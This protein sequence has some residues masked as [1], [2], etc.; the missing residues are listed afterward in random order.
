MLP[1]PFADTTHRFLPRDILS[2][3]DLLH[4]L[5]EEARNAYRNGGEWEW[6]P[7]CAE[8]RP[9]PYF[10]DDCD[11]WHKFWIERGIEI[12]GRGVYRVYY[13]ID[14]SGDWE[15]VARV[16]WGSER[17]E[18]LAEHYSREDLDEAWDEYYRWCAENGSDPL[19][20]FM[21]DRKET[22]PWRLCCAEVSGGVKLEGARRLHGPR[23]K[24]RQYLRPEEIPAELKKYL[25]FPETRIGPDPDDL[26][27]LYTDHLIAATLVDGMV[28]L[29]D[30]LENHDSGEL[31]SVNRDREPNRFPDGEMVSDRETFFVDL[32]I[33]ERKPADRIEEEIRSTA[34]KALADEQP[35]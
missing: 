24:P 22:V 9:R 34:E 18:E 2:K 13:H 3:T 21:V 6:S 10:C 1:R 7:R 28:G 32:E 14:Q 12:E 31:V 15:N 23:D 30:L 26:E 29:S 20:E 25:H 33:E 35:A 16:E 19:G 11:T 17:H 5:P 4:T 8:S 27:G